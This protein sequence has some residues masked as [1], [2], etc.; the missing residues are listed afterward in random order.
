MFRKLTFLS[1]ILSIVSLAS[2]QQAGL[3]D[4]LFAE[5]DRA[6]A[7]ANEALANVLA[8]SSYEEAADHYRSAD[9]NLSRGRSLEGIRSDLEDAVAYFNEAIESAAVARVSLGAAISARDDAAE[10]DA[11]TYAPEEWRDAEV[12]FASAA[13]RL[14]GGNLN[15]ARREAAEAEEEYRAAELIAIDTNYLSGA[16]TRIAEAEDQRVERYAPITLARAKSLLAEAEASLRRDRY[17]T[18]YPRTLAREANYEAQHATYLANRIRAVNDRDTTNEE[19][20][21]E[22]EAPIVR[23]AGELD[24][25]AELDEGFEQPTAEILGELEQLRTDRETLVQRNERIS[26]LE[27]EMASLEARIGDESE[28]RQLQEQIQERFERIAAVFTREEAQVLRRG[29]DVIVRMSLNF[30]SGSS[31]IKPEYFQLLRKIQT[32]IDVFPGS[33]VEVQGH[34]DSFG[35]DEFNMNL[36]LERA[37]AVQQYLLANMNLG[38]STISAEGYGETMP[39]AN[40]ETPEGRTRN[41]R[42]DLLI[43]P[44]LDVLIASLTSN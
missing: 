8:P 43:Q 21:L 10:A 2:A 40:N 17:D 38:S 25:V 15:R 28:Q 22:A 32:A 12:T 31:V 36:S 18:D 5:A 42:I 20:L 9:T 4:Q 14:E 13:R 16:R 3:R 37:S 11:A 1:I 29:N 6:M 34:T 44:D 26:F 27:N 39:L 35:A 7:A 23:I 19:L 24:L 41:R 33:Q 30:D